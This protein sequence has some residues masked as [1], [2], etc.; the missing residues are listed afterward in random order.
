MVCIKMSNYE[1]IKFINIKRQESRQLLNSNTIR[2]GI[3]Q[4]Q[5]VVRCPNQSSIPLPDIKIDHLELIM[6]KTGKIPEQKDHN[7]Q[8][9]Q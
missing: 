8:G 5:K 1:Q 9:H 2:A 3:N 7:D 4:N 6:G